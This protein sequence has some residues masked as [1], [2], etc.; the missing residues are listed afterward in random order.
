M[1]DF[2][3]DHRSYFD[4]IYCI[5][6]FKTL[7]DRDDT[8]FQ[9][10]RNPNILDQTETFSQSKTNFNIYI[11]IMQVDYE[12]NADKDLTQYFRFLTTKDTQW[13]KSPYDNKFLVFNLEREQVILEQA[14]LASFLEL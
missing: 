11:A 9:T 7:K 2:S 6:K 8:Q 4:D 14:I 12:L 10:Y 3:H 13:V 1:R 5:K